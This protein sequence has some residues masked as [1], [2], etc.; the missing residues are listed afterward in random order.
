MRQNVPYFGRYKVDVS[1]TTYIFNIT[2]PED[3]PG[4]RLGLVPIFVDIGD[5][6]ISTAFQGLL[7]FF[8][9]SI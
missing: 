4:P 1:Y 9:L 5:R 7:C 2:A 6:V 3:S 8:N